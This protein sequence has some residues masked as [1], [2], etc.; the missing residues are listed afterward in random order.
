[1]PAALKNWDKLHTSYF[2]MQAFAIRK[3]V[4]LFAK[5]PTVGKRTATRFAL[6]LIKL[7]QPDFQ[8]FIKAASH[9]RQDIKLCRFCQQPFQPAKP[10]DILCAICKNPAREQRI[11]CVVEKETD[12]E[13]I[14]NTKKYKG[15]YF[16][17]G[18]A[19]GKLKKDGLPDIR[20]EQ[21]KERLKNPEKFGIANARFQELIIATNPTLEGETTRLYLERALK[22]VVK[23]ITRLGRGLPIGGEV[24]YADEETLA[25]ALE[26][27]A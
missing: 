17:L 27:R 4:E 10:Q 5:F 3:L 15:L 2:S 18:G 13:A 12:L 9:V 6:Y 26:H 16:V 24:E 20:T 1:M 22:P 14:E 23:K 19:L 11:L 7:P 25:S 8:E 21:L